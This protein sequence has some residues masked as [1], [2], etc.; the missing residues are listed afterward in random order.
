M[1]LKSYFLS[2]YDNASFLRQQ[3]A[4]ALMYVAIE[5]ARAGEH[6][7]GFSVVVSTRAIQDTSAT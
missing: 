1:N 4:A 3:K 5:A 6:G 7:K 2:R